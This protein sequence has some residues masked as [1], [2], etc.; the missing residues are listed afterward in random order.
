MTYLTE[1][2]LRNFSQSERGLLEK[3]QSFKAN[4]SSADVTIFLSHSHKDKDL[5]IAIMEMVAYFGNV[6]IY[7]DW[8]DLT[9]PRDTNRE[10]VEKIKNNILKFDYF[11]ILATENAIVSR[12]VP[13]EIGIAEATKQRDRIAIIPIINQNRTFQGNEYL[14]LYN[15]VELSEDRRIG[16]F[17]PSSENGYLLSTWI[18]KD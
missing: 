11:L 6:E 7:T 15:R 13:W 5:A 4:V 12:W 14:Q 9:M 10:T 16:V 1:N 18:Q 8:N 3:S 2:D 17:P